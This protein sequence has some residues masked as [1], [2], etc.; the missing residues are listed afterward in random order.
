MYYRQAKATSQPHSGPVRTKTAARTPDVPF[1]QYKLR[2]L[3]GNGGLKSRLTGIASG[4]E[5]GPH[6][7]EYIL[8]TIRGG[9]GANSQSKGPRLVH[10]VTVGANERR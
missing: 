4:C 6:R 3:A 2:D 9:D 8:R 1:V 10:G 5:Q 7:R